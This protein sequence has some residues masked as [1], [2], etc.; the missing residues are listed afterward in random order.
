[1]NSD[2]TILTSTEGTIGTQNLTTDCVG[3]LDDKFTDLENKIKT[4]IIEEKEKLEKR[5][6]D[7]SNADWDNV[8]RTTKYILKKEEVL[9]EEYEKKLNYVWITLVGVSFMLLFVSYMLNRLFFH[10]L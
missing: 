6:D 7:L 9:R 1:M 10:I 5:C 2:L 4:T 8:V 3:G